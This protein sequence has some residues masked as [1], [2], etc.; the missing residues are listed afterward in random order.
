MKSI[1]R[2]ACHATS[3]VLFRHSKR[4]DTR[5]QVIDELSAGGF[6]RN[7]FRL[8]NHLYV[9]VYNARDTSEKV[10][11]ARSF[12]RLIS[13]RAPRRV[14]CSIGNSLAPQASSWPP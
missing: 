2:P 13:P 8:K 3:N 5:N 6:L 7:S 11:R 1:L 9:S 12:A 14:I 4:I 10:V